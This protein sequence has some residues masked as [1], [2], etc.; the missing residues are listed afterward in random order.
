[1]PNPKSNPPDRIL[2]LDDEETIRET[3][4]AFLT[5]EGFDVVCTA[6]YREALQTLSEKNFQAAVIDRMLGQGES[7][8]DLIK[9]LKPL[10]PF[11]E[12]LLISAFPTFDSARETVQ[13]KSSAYLTKPVQ[14]EELCKQVRLAVRE[15]RRKEAEGKNREL[16]R[17]LFDASTNPI[18]ISDTRGGPAFVNRAFKELFGYTA[19]ELIS[20]DR[21]NPL[22]PESDRKQSL[23]EV[24]SVIAGTRVP[25]RETVR[26]TRNG[27]ERIV[28][29]SLSLCKTAA[30]A[31]GYLLEIMHDLTEQKKIEKKLIESERLSM[32]G[33]LSAKVAHEINNPLQAVRGGVEMV[34]DSSALDRDDKELLETA[35][36]GIDIITHL[37]REFMGIA[38]PQPRKITTFE[39]H[40]PIEQA[41]RFLVNTGAIKH[42]HI[43][44]IFAENIPNLTGDLQ[45][46]QQ[47]FMNLIINAAHAMK[48][49]PEKSLYFKTGYDREQ[50]K[51]VLSV[52][53]TGCGMSA[54]V[55]KQIFSSFYTTR[56]E[57]GGTG[58]GLAVVKN[59]VSQH[60]GAISLDSSIGQGTTF[61]LTFP[62]EDP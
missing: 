37:T 61:I 49:T 38:R 31:S 57:Q 36:E 32:L 34:L 24:N 58:L 20:P 9:A 12:T 39:P 52:R 14:K 2:I 41:I 8:L 16:F 60:K 1:M 27:Q 13:L 11:C 51:I 53:D 5:R 48:S 22:V 40:R 33:Q 10:Q 15:S 56:S 6:S 3:F 19:E 47:V 54:S 35:V 4:S 18:V 45:Q 25:D 42:F 23:S 7:G 44:K 29:T 30:G 50:N 59:I 17:S 21:K 43:E 26:L 28:R 55:K 62:A 46:L